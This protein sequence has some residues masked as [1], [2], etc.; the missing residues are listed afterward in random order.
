MASL[1]RLASIFLL[2]ILVVAKVQQIAPTARP[3]FWVV[4]VLVFLVITFSASRL[5]IRLCRWTGLSE[6]RSEWVA[7]VVLLAIVALAVYFNRGV[8]LYF[9]Q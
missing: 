9:L 6:E 8:F 5:S 2:L 1:L 7:V 3:V 4:L